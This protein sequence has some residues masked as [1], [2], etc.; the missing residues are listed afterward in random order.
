[1]SS[2]QSHRAFV[3]FDLLIPRT[4]DRSGIVHAPAA[5]E[6][7]V[8]ETSERFGGLT[9]LGANLLG[10]WFDRGELVEDH[11]HWYRVAVQPEQVAEL[12][13]HVEETARRFG[14]RC[15]YLQRSGDAELVWARRA[16]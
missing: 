16:E 8:L 2:S 1:V 3:V 11:S 4:D 7:W 10:Y 5:F 12:R 14:Q 9:Q 15:L 6:R 13:A